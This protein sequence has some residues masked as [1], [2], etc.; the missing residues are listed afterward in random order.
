MA[1]HAP[2]L[3]ALAF[4]LVLPVLASALGID[5][6]VGISTRILILALAAIALNLILGY[7]GLVSFGH[8]AFFGLGAYVVAILGHH[9]FMGEALLT[10]PI[11]IGGTQRA[12]IAWPL[13]MAA[14]ALAALV[15]GA[16]SLRTSGLYFIMITLAFAQML[17]FFFV[18]LEAYGGDD[19]LSLFARSSAGPLDLHDAAQFY[20]L[21]LAIVIAA[22]FLTRRIVDSR[23]GF[24]LQGIRDN[25]R[26]MRALGFATMRLK[27]TAFV[28][29]GAIAGLAGA[30]MA[31][32][33]E[34]VSP[35]FLSWQRSGEILVIVVLGGMGT[36]VGPLVGAI[37][38]FVLE[39]VLSQWT[40]HW[41]LFFGPL[42]VLAVLFA[43]QGLWGMVRA[44]FVE[45]REVGAQ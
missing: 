4:A 24:A 37:V 8:A 5:Y 19:G 39:E 3:A 16:I 15:I 41:M 1:K 2:L 40:Q 7:G 28:I 42:L 36:I 29:S 21:V 43:K 45:R 44:R 9:S 12:I 20:Y 23:F 26:R 10:W 18:S 38:F 35:A 14:S 17:Y 13:A 34:F 27:L 6:A 30:L 31:N 22:L 11:E 33:T 25:E 32:H